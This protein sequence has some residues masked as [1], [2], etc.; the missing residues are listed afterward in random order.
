MQMVKLY[1]I[2][3]KRLYVLGRRASDVLN[4][5]LYLHAMVI[6]YFTFRRAIFIFICCNGDLIMWYVNDLCMWH[7]SYLGRC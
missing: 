6:L 3:G 5:E 2:N 4:G 1:F 7:D